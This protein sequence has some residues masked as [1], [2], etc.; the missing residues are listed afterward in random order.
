MSI[1]V[2][3]GTQ[4]LQT[5]NVA[6]VIGY[7]DI[8][9]LKAPSLSAGP[10]GAP[11]LVMDSVATGFDLKVAGATQVVGRIQQAGDLVQA[12]ATTSSQVTAAGKLAVCFQGASISGS[13]L[14]SSGQFDV[15]ADTANSANR[16]SIKPTGAVTPV[17]SFCDDGRAW[18]T[19][20][21]RGDGGA[22]YTGDVAA[23][24]L[25]AAQKLSVGVTGS[26]VSGS[27]IVPDQ[28]DITATPTSLDFVH[29]GTTYFQVTSSG[30]GST[31]LS[32]GKVITGEVATSDDATHLLFNSV[33]KNIVATAPVFAAESTIVAPAIKSTSAL[34]LLSGA[35]VSASGSLTENTATTWSLANATASNVLRT[36]YGG[37]NLLDVSTVGVVTAAAAAGRFVAHGLTADELV[38]KTDSLYMSS[39]NLEMHA[40]GFVATDAPF[41]ANA[42][43]SVPKTNAFQNAQT[44]ADAYRFTINSGNLR[45]ADDARTYLTLT[46]DVDGGR[47]D[48]TGNL[49]V[50]NNLFVSTI[51][52]ALS[53]LTLKGTTITIDADAFNVR[54][55]INQV[56]TTVLDVQDINITLGHNGTGAPSGQDSARDGAG[57]TIAG[58]I[59]NLPVG[60]SHVDYAHTLKWRN[61]SGLF[62]VSGSNVVPQSRCSWE[63]NGD[64]LTMKGPGAVA[65]RFIWS[66]DGSELKLFK[67]LADNTVTLVTAFS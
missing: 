2:S 16:L 9:A 19:G 31:Q 64:N 46:T 45:V 36:A 29:A 61:N 60:E 13:Q 67:K 15:Y 63:V 39:S 40:T 50:S 14:T 8:L 25:V 66:V 58:E 22:V 42:G 49:A 65:T 10:A 17:A 37:S 20:S 44:A 53:D 33:G 23:D 48:V 38:A 34:S 57:I 4:R 26:V 43:L 51:G 32:A 62:D 27:A 54:S 21:L 7:N 47:T 35:T 3:T 6:N 24:N 1:T 12:G 56:N 30:T 28:W 5:I 52:D 55:G 11:V 41:Y 18:F 59:V